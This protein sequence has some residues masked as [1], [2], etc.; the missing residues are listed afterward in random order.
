MAQHGRADPLPIAS[1]NPSARE[2]TTMI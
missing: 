1:A 2:P